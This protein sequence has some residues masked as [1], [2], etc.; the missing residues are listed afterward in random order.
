MSVDLVDAGDATSTASC[1]GLGV[2]G[3]A[4]NGNSSTPAGE[5]MLNFRSFNAG[6]SISQAGFDFLETTGGVEIGAS[7]IKKFLSLAPSKSKKEWLTC[8]ERL[9]LQL[10][11]F[12]TSSFSSEEWRVLRDF[13]T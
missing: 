12:G 6:V 3:E 8:R 11:G 4:I 1:D 9:P 7:S 2:T 13:A 10:G 5:L